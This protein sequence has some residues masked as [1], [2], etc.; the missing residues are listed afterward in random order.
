MSATGTIKR[1]PI[2]GSVAIRTHFDDTN[3]QLAGLAWLIGTPNLGPRSGTNTD[4]ADWDVL[5]DPEATP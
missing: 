5:Y 2:T 4:V 1:D 3:P